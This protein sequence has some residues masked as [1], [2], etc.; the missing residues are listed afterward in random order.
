V[1]KILSTASG[2]PANENKGHRKDQKERQNEAE[3][4]R[5]HDRRAGLDQ[6]AP[7]DGRDTYLGGS[8]TDQAADQRMRAERGN[9]ERPG[10]QVPADRAHQGTENHLIVDDIGGNDAGSDR[11]RHMEAKEQ[12]RDEIEES[13]PDHRIVRPQDS[14]RDDGRNGV[15][16]VVQA[17]EKIECQSDS[18]QADE[19]GK[20][21]VHDRASDML[22][23]DAG[24]PVRDVLEPVDDFFEM[25]IEFGTDNER[26][27]IVVAMRVKKS[28]Q[29]LVVDFIGFVLDA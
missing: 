12:E 18:D 2:V 24:D 6:T 14:R 1:R 10:R 11:L 22:D 17:I 20:G 28:G 3:G 27:G 29:P 7:N 15:R 4:R 13:R 9:T 25:T 5:E 23:H 21:A 8:R 19:K 26:H 16:R